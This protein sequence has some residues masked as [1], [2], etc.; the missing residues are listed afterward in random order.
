MTLNILEA[1]IQLFALFAA[2]RGKGHCLG[3]AHAARYMRNQLPK[4]LVDDSLARFD[5]LVDQFQRMPGQGEEMKAKRL[6]S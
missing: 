1:L 2:G 3:R 4:A 6:A 5:E